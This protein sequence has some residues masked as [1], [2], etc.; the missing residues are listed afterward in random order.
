MSIWH[1][2]QSSLGSLT[3][4][5]ISGAILSALIGALGWFLFQ[6]VAKPFRK[7]WDLRGEVAHAM[8]AYAQNI[9]EP[10]ENTFLL[11]VTALSIANSRIE[12][13]KEFRRLGLA[14]LSFWQS[15]PFA[16]VVL[17]MIGMHGDGAARLLLEL[18]EANTHTDRLGPRRSEIA[19]T[20][21]LK[22]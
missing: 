20:L 14:M 17:R 13:A 10:P 19:A 15:E 4:I 2:I 21:R 1:L 11:A 18:A 8:N 6:F 5:D 7:F 9:S 22:P 3:L 16:R 12:S